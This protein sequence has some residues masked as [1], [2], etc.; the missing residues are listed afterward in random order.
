[1]KP[2]PVQASPNASQ[3]TGQPEQQHGRCRDEDQPERLVVADEEHQTHARQPAPPTA[4]P[5][6][7]VAMAATP[8]RPADS[9]TA[10]TSC[11]P[12]AATAIISPAPTRHVAHGAPSSR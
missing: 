10:Q 2:I 8:A 6:A 5:S 4:W 12:I 7:N 11:A 3:A 1:M 9:A